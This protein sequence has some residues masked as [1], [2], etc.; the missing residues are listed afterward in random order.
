MPFMLE[1]ALPFG[2]ISPP[3][4]LSPPAPALLDFSVQPE[5]A[6]PQ[7]TANKTSAQ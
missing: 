2:F 5:P 4:A 1:P 3:V 7:M 6:A